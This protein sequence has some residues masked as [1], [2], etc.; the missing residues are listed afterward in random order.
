LS[1][2]RSVLERLQGRIELERNDSEGVTFLITIPQA[3]SLA[4][5]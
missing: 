1:L 5:A 2:C 4:T 3:S